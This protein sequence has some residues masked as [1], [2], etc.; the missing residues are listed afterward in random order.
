MTRY[1]TS[2]AAPVRSERTYRP[3][4]RR[5]QRPAGKEAR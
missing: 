1:E 3:G 2:A 4:A 5:Q